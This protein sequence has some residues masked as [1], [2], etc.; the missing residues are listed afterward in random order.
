[1]E[2]RSIRIEDW[3]RTASA[4]VALSG[5]KLA[6][7]THH[8]RAASTWTYIPHHQNLEKWYDGT[9]LEMAISRDLQG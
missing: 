3:R 8:H 9:V 1:M 2:N 7:Y 4:L 6:Q 5:V